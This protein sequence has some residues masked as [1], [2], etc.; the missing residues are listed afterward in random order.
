[1]VP[2]DVS[3][4]TPGVALP[5]SLRASCARCPEGPGGI[6]GEMLVARLHVDLCRMASA[7]CCG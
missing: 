1:M 3:D 6:P 4:K 5:C 7:I 2:Q